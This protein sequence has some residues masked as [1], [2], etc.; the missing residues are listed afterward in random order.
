MPWLETAPV[1]E[2][3]RFIADARLDLYTMTTS[4]THLHRI[5]GKAHPGAF[6]SDWGVSP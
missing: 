1:S 3:E 2:R 4:G 5:T 6:W